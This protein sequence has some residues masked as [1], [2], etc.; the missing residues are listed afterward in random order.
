MDGVW[1]RDRSHEYE[2]VRGRMAT[3]VCR[4]RCGLSSRVSDFEAALDT[5]KAI[6]IDRNNAD[7]VCTVR[8]SL[9]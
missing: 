9:P 1:S 8:W 2:Q 4:S 5:P 7:S 6:F 3:V